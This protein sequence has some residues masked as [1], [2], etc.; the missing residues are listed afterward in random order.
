M[1]GSADAPKSP[2]MGDLLCW[3]Q[4]AHAFA[5]DLTHWPGAKN[6]QP[7]LAH[8]LDPDRHPLD[9]HALM[10][11]QDRTMRALRAWFLSEYVRDWHR[12]LGWETV[13]QLLE[14]LYP[15]MPFPTKDAA[16]MAIERLPED[17]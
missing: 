9:V 15:W 7:V 17:V 3:L 12:D 16:R 1:E 11:G 4:T 14:R 6:P 5:L 2:S 8:L 13:R 10:S